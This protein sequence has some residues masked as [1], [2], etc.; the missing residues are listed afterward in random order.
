MSFAKRLVQ[1][2]TNTLCLIVA[3]AK[4]GKTAWY[5]IR[6]EPV[7]FSKFKNDVFSKAVNLA[8]YGEVI[9]R[10]YGDYPPQNIIDKMVREHGYNPPE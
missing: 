1:S 5:F 8:N 3:P 7:K 6:V 4:G 2:R 9:E 10:G